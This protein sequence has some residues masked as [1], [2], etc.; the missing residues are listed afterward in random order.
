MPKKSALDAPRTNA[1]L[2]DPDKVI[3][4]TDPQ[5]PLYD[6]R[7]NWV[8]KETMV[9]SIMKHGVIKAILVRKNGPDVE[10]I[11][12]RRRVLHAREANRRLMANGEN[13]IKIQA[14]L[15]RGDEDDLSGTAMAANMHEQDTV[16][17][18]ARK[19]QKALDRGRSAEEI[20]G[21]LD[22]TVECLKNQW[23]PLLDL[24]APL[25][26]AIEDGKAA[27]SALAPLAKLS[28][29]VQKVEFEKLMTAGG[30]TV[31]GVSGEAVRAPRVT[32]RRAAAAARGQEPAPTKRLVRKVAVAIGEIDAEWGTLIAWVL[33]DVTTESAMA[34]LPPFRKAIKAIQAALE[35]KQAKK[36]ERA[37]KKGKRKP[38]KD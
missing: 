23:L 5:H 36:A 22:V 6:E 18:K 28:H 16:M 8:L 14:F 37:K 32:G 26:K 31:V 33:G 11:D 2:L 17:N 1:F 13:P 9:A 34:K 20:A 30:G 27:P 38:K 3:V 10:V 21:D 29:D 4:V 15:R 25:K 24:A 12:G 7:G 35:E 19:A